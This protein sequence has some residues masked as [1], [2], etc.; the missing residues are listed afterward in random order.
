RT[1]GAQGR[2]D[3]PDHP[4]P[5]CHP[6]RPAPR[7][8]VPGGEPPGLP[9]VPAPDGAGRAPGGQGPG[10][11]DATPRQARQGLRQELASGRRPQR[12]I[13]P[14]IRGHLDDTNVIRTTS[15][16]DTISATYWTERIFPL[17][18]KVIRTDNF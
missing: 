7:R 8:P 11:T 9:Q 15:H 10:R 3:G 2:P 1:A 14:R 13:A 18:R 16:S 5:V 17:A 6:R 12:G 4:P